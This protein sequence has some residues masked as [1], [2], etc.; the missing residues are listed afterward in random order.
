MT[1]METVETTPSF[2]TKKFY[3]HETEPTTLTAVTTAEL[4]AAEVITCHL[5]E[6]GVMFQATQSTGAPPR[7]ECQIAVPEEF[8]Q[9]QYPVQQVQY[10]RNPQTEQTPGSP[11]NEA[12]QLLTAGTEVWVQAFYG[13]PNDEAPSVGDAY[14]IYHII[15][16]A[17]IEAET[18]S[19]EYDKYSTNQAWK[20]ANGALP[21]KGVMAAG[22]P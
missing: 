4:A 10:S 2:G 7:K 12:Q 14:T 3:V 17:Q 8:G 11:G 15:C 6:T 22:T 18:G 9:V 1:I 21:V 16:G 13:L 5:Y 19:G 20:L